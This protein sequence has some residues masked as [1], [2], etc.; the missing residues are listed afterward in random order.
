[1][2]KK[3]ILAREAQL[4]FSNSAAKGFN[5]ID[6]NL[7]RWTG[8]LT[9][10]T[11]TGKNHFVFE[12][13][14]PELF[15]NVPPI[16]KAIGLMKHP[17]ID[18][19][20]NIHLRILDNWRAEFHLYQVIIALKNLMSRVPPTPIGK[21]IKYAK[22]SAS[23]LTDTIQDEHLSSKDNLHIDSLNN[24][25]KELHRILDQK[26]EEVAKLRAQ[27]L[28]YNSPLK[29]NGGKYQPLHIDQL[30]S[31]R[32]AITD[33]LTNLENRYSSGE[34]S[35]YEYARLYKKYTK[36]LYITRKKEKYLRTRQ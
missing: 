6:N 30:E 29:E 15:P 16:A 12:I 4:V 21:S 8:T 17:N 3:S 34:I 18:N 9:Y 7:S 36:D 33:L 20:G 10:S 13:L 2:D 23:K 19:L 26:E 32:M 5:P 35:I 27:S 28:R 24:E 25:L 14:L 22:D 31:E 1:M 11:R